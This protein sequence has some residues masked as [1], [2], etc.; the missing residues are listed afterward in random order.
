MCES[1]LAPDVSRVS[2]LGLELLHV[3][4]RLPCIHVAVPRTNFNNDIPNVLKN[5]L[6]KIEVNNVSYLGHHLRV[7]THVEM[8]PLLQ[9]LP[10]LGPGLPEAVGHVSLLRLIPAEGRE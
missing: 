10:D 3:T 6:C 1:P 5:D 2:L 7:T 4:L 8:R 9:Q